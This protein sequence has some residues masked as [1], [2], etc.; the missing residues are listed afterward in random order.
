M[1]DVGRT[2]SLTDELGSFIDEQVAS[3]RHASGS[4]VVREALRRYRDDVM[5]ERRHFD[6]LRGLAERGEADVAAGRYV[7]LAT[8]DDVR[9]HVRN[10]VARRRR[11]AG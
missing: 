2:F 1:A 7:E 4:E 10:S 6:H 3:G 9:A 8:P 5:R 11:P